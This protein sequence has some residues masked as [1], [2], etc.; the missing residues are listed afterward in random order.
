MI[1][2][3]SIYHIDRE[4]GEGSYLQHLTFIL[5]CGP[6]LGITIACDREEHKTNVVY[7]IA[8]CAKYEGFDI[9]H[10]PILEDIREKIS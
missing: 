1:D 6:L 4:G 7:G 8:V 9:F 10:M 2:I 3:I 5:L